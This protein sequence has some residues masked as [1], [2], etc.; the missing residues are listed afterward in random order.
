[1]LCDD[2]FDNNNSAEKIISGIK[3]NEKLIEFLEDELII[4]KESKPKD[5]KYSVVFTKIRDEDL[6]KWITEHEGSV[7]DS[8]TKDTSILVVPAIGVES[9]KVTKAE[10]YGIPVVAI[11][12]L[13]E[14]IINNFI[15]VPF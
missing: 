8:L 1:M 15:E 12:D 13:K 2:Y 14:Y 11:S 9:S 5:F 6:E 4:L 3:E 10:K 7:K